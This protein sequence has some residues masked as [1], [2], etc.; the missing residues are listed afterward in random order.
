MKIL[1]ELFFKPLLLIVPLLVGGVL[2]M[3]AV[4]LDLLSFLK[5]PLHLWA[6]GKNKTYRGVVLMPLF[7]I[8]GVFL[9][10]AIE[11][12]LGPASEFMLGFTE[13]S[14]WG[15]GFWLGVGY[16]LAELPNS[17]CKRRLGVA[18]GE[19]PIS[20]K[21][22]LIMIY[23]QADSALGCIIVYAIYLHRVSPLTLWSCVFLGTV[24]HLLFNYLLFVAKIRN[25]PC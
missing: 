2:H 3:V 22:W 4:K 21:R 17:F 15:L 19:L 14:P 7:C 13:V 5:I 10:R 1:I 23:D 6:F 18:E 20:K 16:I 8:L 12:A 24:L 9:S 11:N 25:R